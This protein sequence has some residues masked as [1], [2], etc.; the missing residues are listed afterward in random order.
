MPA[1]SGC[2][3]RRV[4]LGGRVNAGA[5]AA[6]SAVVSRGFPAEASVD[7]TTAVAAA[8]AAVIIFSSA[9][10]CRTLERLRGLGDTALSDI[11]SSTGRTRSAAG[12]GL[13]IAIVAAGAG[14]RGLFDHTA[15]G[16]AAA[17]LPRG[18]GACLRGDND[19]RDRLLA[20]P[21]P[22]PVRNITRRPSCCTSIWRGSV[23]VP[24]P[25]PS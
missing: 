5:S 21:L 19:L 2:V 11:S 7:P 12:K 4:A 16:A 3:L 20:P 23:A 24:V 17:A 25:W 18:G 14:V 8:G 10:M 9:S 1:C 15:T 22:P 6:S 13:V